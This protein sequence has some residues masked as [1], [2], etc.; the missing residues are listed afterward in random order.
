MRA[1]GMDLHKSHPAQQ[2]IERVSE[3]LNQMLVTYRMANG[4]LAPSIYPV[5]LQMLV[6]EAALRCFDGF[7]SD[8]DVT[9]G[10]LAD[11]SWPLDRDLVTDVLVNAMENAK[12]YAKSKILIESRLEDGGFRVLVADDGAGF[13]EVATQEERVGSSGVGLQLAQAIAALHE[14]HGRKGSL[15]LYNGMLGGAVFDLW[16]P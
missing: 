7:E 10:E 16:L 11:E 15:K 2:A 9:V 4:G 13:P 1:T 12:R 8:I 5:D 3:R 6:S 14:R